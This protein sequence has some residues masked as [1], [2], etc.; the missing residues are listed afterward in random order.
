MQ[1]KISETCARAGQTVQF[2]NRSLRLTRV[3][4]RPT[5][6]TDELKFAEGL[7]CFAGQINARGGAEAQWQSGV[8]FWG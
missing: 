2:C 8:S 4:D 3:E 1:C 5:T 6:G 7:V